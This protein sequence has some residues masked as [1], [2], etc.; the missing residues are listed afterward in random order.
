MPRKTRYSAPPDRHSDSGGTMTC[1]SVT[2]LNEDHVLAL[3][4]REKQRVK[5]MRSGGHVLDALDNDRDRRKVRL[6]PCRFL[7]LPDVP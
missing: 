6:A 7:D 2:A 1:S 4:R 5:L 3:Q